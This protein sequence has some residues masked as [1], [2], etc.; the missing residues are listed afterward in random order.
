M[1]NN[2]N[3]NNCNGNNSNINEEERDISKDEADEARKERFEHF[4]SAWAEK[5]RI[6]DLEDKR[7]G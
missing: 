5:K 7:N 2:C 1:R 3:G 6:Q 4:H